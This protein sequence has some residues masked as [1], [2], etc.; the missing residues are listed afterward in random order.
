MSDTTLDQ[1]SAKV[2]AVDDGHKVI[3]A[4]DLG[5]NKYFTSGCLMLDLDGDGV[6]RFLEK[7]DNFQSTVKEQ[8]KIELLEDECQ[9]WLSKSKNLHVVLELDTKVVLSTLLVMQSYLGSDLTRDFL[10]GVRYLQGNVTPRLL[11]QPNVA[12]VVKGL[13][14]VRG[15]ADACLDFEQDNWLVRYRART[16]GLNVESTNAPVPVPVPAPKPEVVQPAPTEKSFPI[17]KATGASRFV[18]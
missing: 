15:L 2:K 18:K 4:T 16:K 14:S 17:K 11:F 3:E 6:E 10:C 8:L 7:I 1:T 12:T 13:D 5:V 9:G